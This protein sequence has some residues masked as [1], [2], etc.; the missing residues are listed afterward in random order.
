M[1]VAT[2]VQPV[3][4]SQDAATY[5]AAIDA[6]VNVVGKVAGAFAPHEAA[7][8]AMTIV[9]DAGSVQFGITPVAKTAQTSGTITAPSVNPRI[10]RAVI[11]SIT[12]V[13]SIITGAEAASPVAPALT[14]GKIAIAQIV[15]ATSTTTIT[16]S[17]ITDERALYATETQALHTKLIDIGDW[18]MVASTT[19]NIAHGLTYSKIRKVE[20]LIRNDGDT[21][22][23]DFSSADNGTGTSHYI[24]AA[25]T[26]IS[27]QRHVGG[28]F[29]N[30]SF[31][32]TSYNRGWITIQYID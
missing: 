29:D 13:L 24:S 5:K 4:T 27:M 30:T 17:L 20:A 3:F 31:D 7:T 11:D 10:D 1:T 2:F 28:F 26:N 6:S 14:A 15:L 25:S 12:G 8:P 21:A 18:N 9:L 32:S 23:Y 19:V 22:S 16:N